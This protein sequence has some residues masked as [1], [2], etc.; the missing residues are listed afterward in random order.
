MKIGVRST[1]S[2]Y[3]EAYSGHP[4]EVWIISIMSFIN[5]LGM[6]VVPF[7]TIYLNTVLHFDLKQ[8]GVLASAFG[9]GSLAGTFIGGR[10]SD[11]IGVNNVI[12]F[13]LLIGGFLLISLQFASHFYALFGLLFI[14]ALFGEAYRPAMLSA[15]SQYV[16]SAQVGRSVALLRLAINLGM[17]VAPAMGGFIA[18][19]WNYSWLFWFD[20][21]T[22]ILASLFFG[23]ISRD[24][25]Q[26][27]AIKKS[28]L[29]DKPKDQSLPAHRNKP[30][31]L[32][33]LS[34][35]IMAFCFMQWFQSV[36]IFIKTIWHYDERYIGALMAL[37]SLLIALI[38]MP[39]IH[40]IE[41]NG[42]TRRATI[43]GLALI[44]ISFVPFLFPQLFILGFIAMFLLTIGEILAL[45]LTNTI[46]INMSPPSRRGE[47]M[48]W[49]WM[50][51]SLVQVLGPSLG[52]FFI[53]HWGFS[54]FWSVLVFMATASVLIHIFLPSRKKSPDISH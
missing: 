35:W 4:K 20:G 36:P 14:T 1:I 22:C 2:L 29:A 40:Q 21:I 41:K 19:T 34:T 25:T 27:K 32:F 38:E 10:V 46:A 48:G 50:V 23:W 39:I 11:R 18:A 49:Y 37:S 3:R 52:L 5:R 54:A 7:L 15:I 47:Y 6:M 24:W 51:W 44:G 45:P 9:F 17:G 16:S 26:G 43:Y 33:I 30:F 42:H 31:L 12:R 28:D 8:S 13:S 53:S